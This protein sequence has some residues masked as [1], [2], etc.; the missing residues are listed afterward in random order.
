MTETERQLRE[1]LAQARFQNKLLTGFAAFFLL[2]WLVT[3]IYFR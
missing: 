1:E 2:A 3:A